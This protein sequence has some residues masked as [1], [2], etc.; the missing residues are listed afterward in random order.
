MIYWTRR[1][2]GLLHCNGATVKVTSIG[3]VIVDRLLAS[4]GRAVSCERL[5]DAV[6]GSARLPEDPK[7]VVQVT[8]CKLRQKGVP[9]RSRGRGSVDG[10]WFDR[11]DIGF[12]PGDRYRI[13]GCPGVFTVKRVI[14]SPVI[15][16]ENRELGLEAMKPADDPILQTLRRFV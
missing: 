14:D 10:Y 12:K 11:E 1:G 8:I 9:I 15:V 7:A 4:P 2:A 3:A 13:D 6:Y 16:F 5:V